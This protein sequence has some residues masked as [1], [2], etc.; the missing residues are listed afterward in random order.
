MLDFSEQIFLITPKFRDFTSQK[1]FRLISESDFD[2]RIK[3][4]RFLDKSFSEF[5]RIIK[6][7][8]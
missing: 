8:L 2:F 1:T 4:Q 6:F 5:F 3:I 7:T